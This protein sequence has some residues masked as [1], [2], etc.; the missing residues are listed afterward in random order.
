M[1]KVGSAAKGGEGRIGREPGIEPWGRVRHLHPHHQFLTQGPEW[2]P[3]IL[4]TLPPPTPA[5]T[6]R[7]H[8][9]VPPG[10]TQVALY[11]AQFSKVYF[12]SSCKSFWENLQTKYLFP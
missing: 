10:P 11:T 7:P 6:E 1:Y 5:H 4:R 9:A 12:M 3:S 8:D 2:S